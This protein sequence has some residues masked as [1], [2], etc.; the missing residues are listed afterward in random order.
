MRLAAVA[1]VMALLQ[2]GAFSVNES[3]PGDP[4][5]GAEGAGSYVELTYDELI[6]TN[7]P[8]DSD[9]SGA[10]SGAA[11]NPPTPTYPSPCN[12]NEDTARQCATTGYVLIPPRTGDPADPDPS[13]GVRPI[14]ISDVERFAPDGPR[15]VVEP[16]GWGIAG[17]PVNVY[18]DS[19]E[20]I[21]E[22]DLMGLDVRIRWIPMSMTVDFGD[23]TVA[24]TASAGEAW[25]D[26]DWLTATDTS[27]VY[28]DAGDFTVTGQI[29]YAPI[30]IVGGSEVPIAGT[31]TVDTNSVEVSIYWV[32]TR[33]TRGDCIEYPSD[34]GCPGWTP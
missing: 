16:D 13:P 23:G 33:L 11:N 32:K 1:L 10:G 12:P 22:G 27:H 31:V 34:P 20:Q 3:E 24:T 18:S 30:I 26:T 5:V 4:E 19:G 7:P 6:G 2:L 28:R 15:I 25:S 21:T 17:K 14:T 8:P 29:E 9:G